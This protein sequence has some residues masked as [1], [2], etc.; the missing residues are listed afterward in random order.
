MK[1]FQKIL[2]ILFKTNLVKTLWFNWKML[3]AREAWRLPVWFYG[4]VKFR[5]LSGRLIFDCPV[6]S[7]LVEVGRHDYYVTTSVPLTTWTIRGTL[8]FAG[9]AHFIQSSYILVADG[10]TLSFGRRNVLGSNLKIMCF[11]R[12]ELGREVHITWECQVMDT[13]FHYLEKVETR[14]AGPLRLS[15]AIG[16]GW[17]TARRLLRGRCSRPI[18]SSLRAVW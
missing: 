7:G 13:R 14:E 8:R 12:I 18:P 15:W 9:M 2:H 17:A 11:D 6:R 3:P 1:R 4:K 16:S 10:A 5:D